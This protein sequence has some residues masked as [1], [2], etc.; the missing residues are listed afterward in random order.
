MELL[1]NQDNPQRKGSKHLSF[2]K[3]NKCLF[4]KENQDKSG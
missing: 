1:S 2:D 3:N 4:S